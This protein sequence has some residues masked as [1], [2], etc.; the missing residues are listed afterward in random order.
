[1]K[2]TGIRSRLPRAT[3]L[4]TSIL[5]ALGLAVSVTAATVPFIDDFETAGGYTAGPLSASGSHPW[6][7]AAP[8]SAEIV[9]SG[10]SGDQSLS[11]L[12]KGWLDFTPENPG[13]YPVT[14]IDFYTRPVFS[15]AAEA[16]PKLK[17][18]HR[19]VAT[20]FVVAD[21]A[22]GELYAASG[23]GAGGGEW[24]ATG[25]HVSLATDDSNR[26]ANWL[27]IS[28]RIDYPLK[29]WDLFVDG[30]LVLPNL[31]FL[32]NTQTGFSQF[33]LRGDEETA[34][35]LDYFYVGGD[36]PLYADASGD[37][38]PDSWLIAHGLS[39]AINQRDLDPDH[40]GLSNLQEY[41]LGTDPTKADTDNDGVY[42]GR[43]VARGTDPKTA[44]TH[45]LGAVPFADSFEADAPGAFADGTRLWQVEVTGEN[46]AVE[47][48]SAPTP[49]SDGGSHYLS[50]TG[51]GIRVERSFASDPASGNNEQSV[52]LDFR[53][54]AAP[55]REAPAIPA[56]VAAVFYVSE[57]GYL[58]ALDGDGAG[59][60]VWHGLIPV[61]AGN[62][63]RITLRLDYGTQR[64]SLWLDGVRYGQNLGFARPV[65]FFSGFAVQ[66]SERPANPA[67]LDDFRVT[68]GATVADEPADLDNDGDGLTNAQERALGTDPDNPDTDGD[69]IR[70]NMEIALGL[71]PLSPEGMIAKLVDEG[72]GTWAWR[73]QFSTAEGYETGPLDGQLGWQAT[74]AA[75]VT[76]EEAVLHAPDADTPATLEHVIGAGGIDRV[77]LSFRARLEVGRLPDPASITGKI[78]SLFGYRN[79][80]K[81]SIYD[82]P[83]GKWV[84][85][86][87]QNLV[88]AAGD[89]NDYVLYLDY[90][91]HRWLLAVNGRL[92]ARD[93]GFRD[94]GLTTIARIRMM[95]EGSDRETPHEARF[96]DIVVS[97]TEPAGLDFDGDDLTN[98]EERLLGTDPFNA[99]TDG[100]GMPDGWEVIHGLNP[101]N[102]ADAS[103]DPDK[104]GIPNL[105]EFLNNL[106]PTQA[107]GP[108]TGI[109]I[110]EEWNNLTGSA[111][112]NLTGNGN[113]PLKPTKI[114]T[115]D[116]LEYG[117][118]YGDNYGTR[119]RGFLVPPVDGNYE[120]WIAGDYSAELW[121]SPT[122][123]PFDRKKIA[124]VA[125]S[126]ATLREWDAQATQAS[127]VIPLRAGQHYY[128]EVLHKESTGTDHLSV[129][130]RIPGGTKVEVI[131]AAHLATFVPRADDLDG[132]GLPDAW[133]QQY[134]ISTVYGYGVH[135]AYGDK[136]GDGLNNLLEY[137]LGTHP[138]QKDTDG[139]GVSDSD[140]VNRLGS[141]PT[142]ADVQVPQTIGSQAGNTGTSVTGSWIEADDGS[143]AMI[144]QT[145][146][147]ALDFT[148]TVPADGV[149]QLE[150]EA[151]S[152]S[153]PTTDTTFPV[154]IS[155]D[156]QVVGRINFVLPKTG[157]ITL[158]RI[159][160]PWLTAGTHTVRFYYDGALSYRY[161]QL[162]A[163]R[164]QS[165]GGVDA[166]NDGTPDWM[167]AR[168]TGANSLRPLPTQSYVSP[169]F[170][171]GTA[172]YFNLLAVS[173]DGES[174]TATPAPSWGWF[175]N[176]PLSAD[177]EETVLVE[178]AFENGALRQSAR[179]SWKALDLSGEL[180]D[181]PERKLR[182]RKGDS[183]LFASAGS[184]SSLAIERTD[185]TTQVLPME[186]TAPLPVLFDQAGTFTVTAVAVP[187]E[188][189]GESTLSEAFTVEVIEAEFNGDPVAGVGFG[190]LVTWDN[191]K[192]R[193]A[194]GLFIEVDQGILLE[195]ASTLSGGG[196]RFNLASSNLGK[197]YAIARLSEEGPVISQAAVT[198][199]QVRSNEK[200]AVDAL[201]FYPDGSILY[202]T[203]IQLSEVTPDTKVVVEIF[204]KGV[205]FED[206]TTKKTFTAADFDALGRI[207][208]KFLYTPGASKNSFCHRIHVYN[209]STYLGT[210]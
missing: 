34:A 207:Y 59:G 160:T 24:I 64:W 192:I 19:T 205:T 51:S 16:L 166:D 204:L 209:G 142:V 28:Y 18:L 189:G 162:N 167:A 6:T 81:L 176:V 149:Y 145:P 70:D 123:S 129:G 143:G 165:F 202:G 102:P 118:E 115:L 201:T 10:F 179:V 105:A 5:A 178:A 97:N 52:W 79:E 197:S 136:D 196:T 155:V 183:L 92:V 7:F 60:G 119:I 1:M 159:I 163:V 91:E 137:Q 168:I 154:E 72:N 12:G 88:T 85:H 8:L 98:E 135:G 20:G 184:G 89:W 190:T 96:D 181:L 208:V 47:V 188:V 130:W 95:Q 14:W 146:R 39:T 56:D 152:G 62:W 58:M 37:G 15:P 113:F 157:A 198:G 46:S 124:S 83:T 173:A 191:P 68:I 139:D 174:V 125:R 57:E 140:E 17:N 66:H 104:D 101:L 185:A 74:G 22:T 26:S 80:G 138:G 161:L 112:S 32:D 23:D 27:R 99:D 50:L 106:D 55:R 63:H 121:L 126:T 120:F 84:E 33:S 141:D 128:I 65:P 164:V 53:L 87:V 77:W 177:P 94:I 148:I 195:K 199:L 35:F 29:R 31:A 61:T 25:H 132:D 100:D 36:N 69:G 110:L 107:D 103:A 49:L 117:P 153:N 9:T 186:E 82:A 13:Q 4:V 194:D 187:E 11:L 200:T 78:S 147:A 45:P 108:Q 109:I 75:T 30:Q 44:E 67:A 158:G 134:G 71:D 90:R 48:L 54:Q 21:A 170:V 40:D 122:D 93:I 171:E 133:E 172:R 43:E 114:T 150:F 3:G 42:D 73:T 156:G 182:I 175:T 210:F 111:V 151:K 127:G 116:K 206:G 193:A 41:L 144:T 203:T 2:K 169:L 180:S 86:D 76:G 38:I 131:T